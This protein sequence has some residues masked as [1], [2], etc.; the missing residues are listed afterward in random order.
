[1][2]VAIATRAFIEGGVGATTEHGLAR[3]ENRRRPIRR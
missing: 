1:M 2:D 3:A